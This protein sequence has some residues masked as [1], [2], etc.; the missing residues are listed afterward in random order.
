MLEQI[1]GDIDDEYDVDDEARILKHTDTRY[2]VK[3]LT[4]V[5]DFNEYFDTR[6]QR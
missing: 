3:A 5:E 1:V 2:T 4:P 6:L